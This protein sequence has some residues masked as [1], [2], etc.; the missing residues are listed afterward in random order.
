MILLGAAGRAGSRRHAEESARVV[1]AIQPRF[2]STL[3]MSPV[4]G[5]PLGDRDERGEFE[6]LTPVEL[7][8]ELRVFLAGLELTGSIFRSNHASNYLALAGTLPKDKARMVQALDGVLNDPEH[9]PFRP[10][11]L[12]GL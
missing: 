8:A 1:N 11:W 9:A 5:T 6:H 10:D 4:P 12:R 2:V 3:V 7:A